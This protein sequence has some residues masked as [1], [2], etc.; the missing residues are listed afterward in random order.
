MATKEKLTN[1][2]LRAREAE[3]NFGAWISYWRA[4]PHRFATEHLQIGLFI[5]QQILMWCF[6]RFDLSMFIASRGL[7]KSYLVAVYCVV[8]CIL[9]P[10]TKI[11]VTSGLKKQANLVIT[12][13]I[14][15]ELILKYPRVAHEIL[16][17]KTGVNECEV[18]F[19]NGSTITTCSPTDNSRG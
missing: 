15:K 11:V 8:R 18:I 2:E 6:D 5:F 14:Q 1:V 9:Y 19:K 13:K 12:Q 3:E 10:E 17:V 16:D 4:N 7:G